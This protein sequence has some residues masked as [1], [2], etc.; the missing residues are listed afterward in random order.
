MAE[1]VADVPAV[2]LAVYAH[3]D[4]PDVAAGGTLARWARAGCRVEVCICA[5]GDKGS[6]DPA[7][8]PA[9][10]VARRRQETEEAGRL[11]GV[12]RHH[13]LGYPDGELDDN[14]ALRGRLVELIRSVRPT[15]VV[16][17]DPTAVF[18][19]STYVNHRDHRTV[20]WAA[21]DA[22]A[23]AAANPHYFPDRGP[24]HRVDTLYLSGT[25]EPD[26]WVDV[27]ATIDTKAAAIACH[28]SQLGDAGEWLRGAVRRRAEEAGREASVPLAE[29]FRRITLP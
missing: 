26:V 19:G 15:A 18:F 14:A 22:V 29:G 6:L 12:N 3:P 21:I 23:P 2:A 7:V 8:H 9:D 24:A 13:W 4:D 10:L 17:P 16:A 11:L 27:S 28:A 25:L 20:G 1:L 5:D